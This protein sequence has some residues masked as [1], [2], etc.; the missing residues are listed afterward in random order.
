MNS[1]TFAREGLTR[2]KVE[3][4]ILANGFEEM[5]VARTDTT[6]LNAIDPI[7]GL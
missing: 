7:F 1:N 2:M 5:N 4:G 3:S 6:I